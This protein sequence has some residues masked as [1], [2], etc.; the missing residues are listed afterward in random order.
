V[1][2]ARLYHIHGESFFHRIP[3]AAAGDHEP[4][5]TPRHR[6]DPAIA[7]GTSA[8]AESDEHLAVVLLHDEMVPP[9]V[10]QVVVV[11]D[12]NTCLKCNVFLV[13]EKIE[14]PFPTSTVDVVE[15]G[16]SLLV[17]NQ[18]E[19]VDQ[20]SSGGRWRVE[21]LKRMINVVTMVSLLFL[22]YTRGF[23]R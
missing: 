17:S 22:L 14:P 7:P 19:P 8:S 20:R 9:P 12:K 18:E 3:A 1:R 5:L 15:G 2:T 13:E 23:I 16:W 11:A 4:L 6:A 21:K 10:V